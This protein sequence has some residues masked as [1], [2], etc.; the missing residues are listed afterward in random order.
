MTALL[1]HGSTSADLIDKNRKRGLKI[2]FECVE[3]VCQNICVSV[4]VCVCATIFLE[5]TYFKSVSSD[6]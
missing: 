4:S 6:K 3:I 5:L 2:I 1:N